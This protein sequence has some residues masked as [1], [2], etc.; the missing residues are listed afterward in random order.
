MNHWPSRS[1]V[2]LDHFLGVEGCAQAAGGDDNRKIMFA[3]DMDTKD[4]MGVST[5]DLYAFLE[6]VENDM[7]T[8]ISFV[9]STAT[10]NIKSLFTFTAF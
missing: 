3:H 5:K 7:D 4:I 2:F 6:I 9:A 1:F 8:S 10:L